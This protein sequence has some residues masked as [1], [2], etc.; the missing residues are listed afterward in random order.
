MRPEQVEEEEE[1]EAAAAEEEEAVVVV[2]GD[3]GECKSTFA[4]H[5]TSCITTTIT[6]YYC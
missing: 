6:P 3:S 1:E 5:T 4:L 2:G